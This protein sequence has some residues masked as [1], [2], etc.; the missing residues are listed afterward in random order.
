[1]VVVGADGRRAGW[2]LV[3]LDDRRFA[4]ASRFEAFR[5]LVDAVDEALGIVVNVPIGLVDQGVRECDTLARE[6]VGPQA[7]SVELTPPRPALATASLPEA[8]RISRR[9]SGLELTAQAHQF[10]QKVIEVDAVLAE[11]GQQEPRLR[12]AD[13]PPAAPAAYGDTAVLGRRPD[14]LA[15]KLDSPEGLRRYA[16][17][18]ERHGARRLRQTQ[19]MRGLR[20]A[21]RIVEGHP[22]LCF[23]ELAGQPLERD[24]AHPEG[25]VLRS[26]LLRRGGVDIPAVLGEIGGVAASD[27]LDAAALAWTADRYC[28]GRAY[29]LPAQN[30][31]QLDGDRVL[32]LWV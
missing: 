8:Q 5:L 6:Q 4:G 10:R 12:A 2:I 24:P 11:R 19:P 16:R 25:L 1:M 30:R 20:P 27:I 18:V 14:K 29:S 17:V 31:W 7:G 28:R 3:A 32:A 22:E 15:E 13:A 26:N 9:L 23:R 21:G